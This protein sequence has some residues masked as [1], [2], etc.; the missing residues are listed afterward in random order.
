MNDLVERYV[1]EVTKRLPEKER[2]DVRQ[3][4]EANIQDML[5]DNPT[6]SEVRE[7]LNR[8]GDPA[9][10]SEKY[11]QKPRYLIS[12]D[13]FE[14]YIRT[15][16]LVVTIVGVVFM[17]IGV[18]MGVLE[19][20]GAPM[21]A[22]EGIINQMID[23]FAAA[24]AGGISGGIEG[25]FQALVI[26]TI[27]FAIIDYSGQLSRQKQEKWTV[28][29]LPKEKVPREAKG[30]KW[31]IPLSNG[32]AEIVLG[33][34]FTI[35]A[36]MVCIDRI[37]II[38]SLRDGQVVPMPISTF[39][40]PSFLRLC[41]IV[42]ILIGCLSV[43]EGVVRVMYRRFCV[44]V[45]LTVIGCNL[46]ELAGIWFLLTRP[47]IFKSTVSDMLKPVLK[48]GDFDLLQFA[49]NGNYNPLLMVIGAACTI[50]F[51]IGSVVTVVKTVQYLYG[52]QGK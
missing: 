8:L 20:V 41:I 21:E 52:T 26:T 23:V 24:T 31:S 48:W 28:E 42:F 22:S 45:C 13:M 37:S 19:T 44:P 12:P 51:I 6:D 30:E 5:S 7:V 50:A 34:C 29:K 9:I 33:V 43:A 4:L 40:T 1:Y 18:I 2:Q 11:R 39:L 17:I 14:S 38:Y 32:V 16:K 25:A 47:A 15:L 27:I 49:A 36:V 46:F 3:E 10:L 35:L